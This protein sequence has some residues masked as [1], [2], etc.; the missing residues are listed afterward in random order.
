MVVQPEK[1]TGCRTCE[2]ICSFVH[3]D[4]FNPM[5]SRVTVFNFDKSGFSVPI[6][7]QQCSVAACM[8]IC[9]VSAISTDE[10]TGAKIVDHNKCLRC[11]MCTIACPFGA[12]VYDPVLDMIAK[13]D[14][15]GGDPQCVKLCPSGALTYQEP[16]TATMAKRKAYAAKFKAVIEEVG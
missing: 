12:S 7:C 2:M 16:T 3:A 8:E 4:E 6:I 15:C 9:P 1:C 5:R 13:C 10:F 11:K 14:L